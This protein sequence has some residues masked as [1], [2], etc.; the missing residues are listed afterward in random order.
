MIESGIVTIGA[1]HATRYAALV[2]SLQ[3]SALGA[4]ASLAR[5]SAD[6]D[7][8]TSLGASS[9]ITAA[10]PN[11]AG[12]YLSSCLQAISLT[13]R[14]AFTQ[15][16]LGDSVRAAA[17]GGINGAGATSRTEIDGTSRVRARRHR[18]PRRRHEPHGC[19]GAD[20]APGLDRTRRRR[21]R[22]A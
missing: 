1:S 13:S 8:L 11:T 20:P 4:S 18:H 10:G 12:C 19:A 22:D 5:N 14:N 16:D 17:G 9:R 7:V 15:L 6:V 2:D 21:H 3:A